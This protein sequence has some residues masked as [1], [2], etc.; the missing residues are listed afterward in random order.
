MNIF[1]RLLDHFSHVRQERFHG[2]SVP[3]GIDSNKDQHFGSRLVYLAHQGNLMPLLFQII[4][5]NA[6]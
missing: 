5:V 2:C 3:A 1:E 4:L 6:D